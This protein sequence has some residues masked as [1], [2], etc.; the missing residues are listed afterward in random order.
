MHY[1]AW[2]GYVESIRVLHELGASPT[3]A[4]NIGRTPLDFAVT[5]RNI[6]AVAALCSTGADPNR[7]KLL[8]AS[9][10]NPKLVKVLLLYG[11]D[12]LPALTQ[13]RERGLHGSAVASME[14][15][16]RV[17]PLKALC[18]RV[19]ERERMTAGVSPMLLM[20]PDP[21][22]V[23]DQEARRRER[24]E[25]NEK[26]RRKRRQSDSGSDEARKKQR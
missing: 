21:E 13:I 4:N 25:Q 9:R 12:P 18:L 19:V 3:Q 16:P 20:M 24:E 1:A 15:W 17:L 26:Q 8:V 22:R 2:N 23:L 10:D 7:P 11:A 5:D 6:K 14:Q